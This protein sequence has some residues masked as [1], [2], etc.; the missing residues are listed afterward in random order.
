MK[1]ELQVRKYEKHRKTET[2]KVY[3]QKSKW[4]CGLFCKGIYEGEVQS[5]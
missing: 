3:G 2:G 4:A 1:R 5:P